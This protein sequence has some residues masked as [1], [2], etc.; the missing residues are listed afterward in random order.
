M[1]HTPW[2]DANQLPGSTELWLAKKLLQRYEWWLFEPH[3]NWVDPC[4][5]PENV[6]FPFAA[7]IAGKIRII[8]FYLPT[9]PWMPQ[10]IVVKNIEPDI[11]YYAFFWDPRT[12]QEHTLGIVKPDED[13]SWEIP[14]QPM[15]S[16]WVL[17]REAKQA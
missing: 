15:L 12:G 10:P 2:E 8:Y 3:Q 4:G 5:S 6:D 1:G 9:F 17:V 11:S 7:G 14:L 16:D 13:G